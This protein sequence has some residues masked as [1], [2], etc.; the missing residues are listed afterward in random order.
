VFNTNIYGLIFSMQEE[1]IQ[2]INQG[3]GGSIVNCSSVLG[4]RG[5]SGQAEYVASKFAVE[6]ITKSVALEYAKSNIRINNVNPGFTLPSELMNIQFEK[7]LT[8]IKNKID[9][10]KLIQDYYLSQVPLKRMIHAEE[11]A[12]IVA[13]LLS[14]ESK[15]VTGQDFIIDAGFTIK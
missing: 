3:G 13:Y 14:D 15:S 2:M 11:V 6:G 9:K 1:I 12:T 8:R 7:Q 5:F 10:E 4:I